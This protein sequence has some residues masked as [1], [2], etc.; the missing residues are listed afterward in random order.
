M[1]F[2]RFVGVFSGMLVLGSTGSFCAHSRSAEGRPFAVLEHWSLG[3][4]GGW[5][6]LAVDADHHR[7]YVTRGNRVVVVDTQT[8]KEVG[9][10]GRA[11]DAHAVCLEPTGSRGWITDS[12]AGKVYAFESSTLRITGSVDVKGEPNSAVFEPVTRSVFVF[13]ARG[14]SVTVIDAS[15]NRVMEVVRLPGRPAAAAS[16]GT[17]TVFA[18]LSDSNSILRIDAVSRRVAANWPLPNCVGP[19]G[20][21]M[22]RT[23]GRVYS[24]CENHTLVELDAASGRMLDS[25]D[26]EAD[27]RDV[28]VNPQRKLVFVTSSGG[29]LDVLSQSSSGGLS[30]EQTLKTQ[31]GARTLAVDAA[32]GRI[33]LPTARF[34]LR[35]GDISEE[36]RFRPIPV[37]GSFEVLVVGQ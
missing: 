28:A 19:S 29:T 14:R 2:C 25:A 31:T 20:V 27:S 15:S 23:T 11:Q 8:G 35:T 26:V 6:S 33:Y 21:A 34:G 9:Q 10:I 3:G 5:A 30:L 18:S 17:G 37:P 32:G 4:E 36:L 12:G 7:L 1:S 22:N 16:D 13:A 24:V